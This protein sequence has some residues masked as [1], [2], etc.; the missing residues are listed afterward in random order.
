MS[1]RP[2]SFTQADITRAVKA[3]AK[4]RVRFRRHGFSAYL[5]GIP[6]SEDF[7]RQYAAAL[8]RMKKRAS[9]IGSERTIPG[10]FNALC[11]SYYRSPEFRDLKPISQ[12]NRRNVIE[13][14]R[15]EHGNKPLARLERS[16]IRGLVEAKGDTPQAANV[17]LK[18]LRLMLNYAV[19]VGM[20]GNNPAIGVR[21]YRTRSDGVHTWSEEEAVAFQA[22]HPIG[23]KARLA[24][25]LLL[26]TAQ[27]KSDVVRMGWQH[28]RGDVI[29]VRQQKTNAALNIPVHPELALVLAAVPRM[30]LTFLTTE[31]GAP[32]TSGGFGNWFRKRCDEAGLPQC[33][34]HGL[35]KLAATRLA[36]AGCSV[37]QVRAITGHKSASEVMRYTKA[38]DQERLARQALNIQ[39]GAEHEQDLSSLS[40]PVGQK[41]G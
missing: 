41:K 29:S 2:S 40:I 18:T 37:D 31:R 24:L 1:R 12:R 17:L 10:S 25:G 30:T 27:R 23:T 22:R 32:F 39:L 35:R 8:E 28:V 36:N 38:A 4:R 3:F 20:I 6:W 9:D 14:F 26:Y 15:S 7:M 13:R 5:T 21:G 19:L 11:V 33:S 34:A 16:H